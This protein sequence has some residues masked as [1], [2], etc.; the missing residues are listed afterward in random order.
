M[1][2]SSNGLI[3]FIPFRCTLEPGDSIIDCPPTF[4]M[5]VFDADVNGA[6]VITG[7]FLL[8]VFLATG[9]LPLYCFCR[10]SETLFYFY[11]D[12]CSPTPTR[13]QSRCR[14]Y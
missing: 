2:I 12:I 6:K 5:Y 9:F 1:Q 3:F 11:L 8:Q 10:L 14:R 4:T 7:A 13:F